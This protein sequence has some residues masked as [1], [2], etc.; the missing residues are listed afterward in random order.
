MQR[1]SLCTGRDTQR[2]FIRTTLWLV[3]PPRRLSRTTNW[4][5]LVCSPCAESY[6]EPSLVWPSKGL[7][8]RLEKDD[9]PGAIGCWPSKRRWFSFWSCVREPAESHVVSVPTVARTQREKRRFLLT[10]STILDSHHPSTRA[11]PQP[12]RQ[13]LSCTKKS[14]TMGRETS[15][16]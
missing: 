2:D 9:G 12:G 5:V 13:Y 4:T 3:L 8:C 14:G 7:C 6:V 1:R 10:R 11:K 15:P 16:S